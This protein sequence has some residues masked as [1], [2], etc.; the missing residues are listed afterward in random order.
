MSSGVNPTGFTPKTFQE[1]LDDITT[2]ANDPAFFGVEFPTTPDSVFG[3]LA[4]VMASQFKDQW[5]LSSNVADQQNRDKAEGKF[6]DDLAALVGL[7]RLLSVGSNGDLL[8]TGTQGTTVPVQTPVQD[9]DGGSVLT[10]NV[11]TLN[12]ALCYNS[13]FSV[14]N[15]LNN[16]LY[17]LNI[18]S[19]VWQITS[20]ASAT[21][22]E[23]ASSFV[24][25]I[26]AQDDYTATLG[27]DPETVLITLNT[28]NNILTTTNDLNLNL[29][30]VSNLTNAVAIELGPLQFLANTL[31]NLLSTLPN[32]SAVTNLS[33]FSLG[34]LEETD[35][36]LRTRMALR[37]QSTGTATKPSIEA[38]ISEL[39]GV[40]STLVVENVTFFVD[41]DGRP[42][43]SYEVFVEGGS[44][45]DIAEE[46]FR[47]KPAGMETDGDITKIV[48]DLNGDQQAVKF[49]RFLIKFAHIR[50]TYIIN[51]E[52]V[53]PSNGEDLIK[54]AVV[55]TG[56]ALKR[57]EDLE[58]TKFFGN[59]YDKV[60]G[61]F[62]TLIEVAIT[63]LAGDTPTFQSTRI[64]VANTTDLDFNVSR[65]LVST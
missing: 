35:S 33:D 23:I 49:S 45:D 40:G 64:P 13:T 43:K 57:G 4:S 52:E 58:P 46:V 29:D 56:N 39:S 19:D 61:V 15:L 59:I 11:L 21:K 28:F 3:I 12:R 30:S 24:T 38:S 8:F 16:Q 53:F 25:L 41:G 31:T 44:E 1:L 22:L 7:T 50:I 14:K 27:T 60:E 42:P 2:R 5:D 18:E 17:T 9:S 54:Q 47:T 6:L 48:I 63:N 55:E 65:V 26:G 37:E 34:R 20:D 62:V 10:Q 51:V 32:I 36:E